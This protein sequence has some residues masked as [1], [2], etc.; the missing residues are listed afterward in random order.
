VITDTT[1]EDELRGLFVLDQRISDPAA[2]AISAE[3]GV[4]TLRGTVGS[5]GA[6]RAAVRDARGLDGVEDV[7]D[8]ISVRL[9]NDDR[10][11]DADI[12]GAALQNLMWDAEVPAD[13]LDVKVE[14]GWVSLSGDVFFQFQSDSAYDDV[15]RLYGVTGVTNAIIVTNP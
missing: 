7:I 9:L 12:R 15:A 3:D 11:D 6:R 2:I 8:E 10:R 13:L 4:V 14:D 1:I 5:F